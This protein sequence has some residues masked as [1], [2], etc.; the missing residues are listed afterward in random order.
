LVGTRRD[1]TDLDV[2]S[3]PSTVTTSATQLG[4]VT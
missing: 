1:Q 4:S 2:S 3:L